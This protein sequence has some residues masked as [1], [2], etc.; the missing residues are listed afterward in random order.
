MY[1]A[2]GVMD[3]AETDIGSLP[4]VV[5]ACVG[6][7][8]G[9]LRVER[10]G[11]QN[12]PVD[13]TLRVTVIGCIHRSVPAPT[14]TAGTAVP[15]EHETKYVLSD[16]TLAAEPDSA[17]TGTGELVRQA[18]KSYRLDD[19]AAAL[20]APH[21]GNR[22]EVIGTIVTGDRSS[23]GA[24]LRPEPPTP[25]TVGAPLLRVETL[26]TISQSSTACSS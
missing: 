18:V 24:G 5:L 21:V 26:R 8:A 12:K 3:M 23:N 15:P 4:I 16:I 9:S 13:S 25:E 7:A 6:L 20:I 10:V 22:V 1:S 17:P 11:N 14:G 19:A 2:D